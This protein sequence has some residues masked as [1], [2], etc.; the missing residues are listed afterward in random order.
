MSS[1]SILPY[2]NALYLIRFWCL[3]SPEVNTG[4]F[5]LILSPR[6][7]RHMFAAFIRWMIWD[8]SES[9]ISAPYWTEG[10]EEEGAWHNYERLD[11]KKQTVSSF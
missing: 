10:P 4:Q 5:L 2:E 9:G 11:K 6:H 8:Q 1:Y 3:K 7:E